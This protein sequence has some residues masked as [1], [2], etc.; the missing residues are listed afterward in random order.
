MAVEKIVLN[1]TF[2]GVWAG[3]ASY[4]ET[5]EVTNGNVPLP[6]TTSYADNSSGFNA[7][8][9][10]ASVPSWSSK[11]WDDNIKPSLESLFGVQ[12]TL[13]ERFAGGVTLLADL[14]VGVNVINP[15]AWL[16]FGV[17]ACGEEKDN[18][19]SADLE[20]CQPCPDGGCGASD[21]DEMRVYLIEVAGYDQENVYDM[22]LDE[23]IEAYCQATSSRQ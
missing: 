22:S 23:L 1:N 6:R 15:L 17:V 13:E 19:D 20:E 10:N 4:G 5:D 7:P 2:A 16:V 12:A 18:N 21:Y 11:I 14:A 8:Q 3:N 9:K